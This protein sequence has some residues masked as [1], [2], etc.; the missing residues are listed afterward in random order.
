MAPAQQAWVSREFVNKNVPKPQTSFYDQLGKDSGV[1]YAGYMQVSFDFRSSLDIAGKTEK[2][3]ER[4]YGNKENAPYFGV[5]PAYQ[6]SN[7]DSDSVTGYLM[8]TLLIFA[9]GYLII[10]NIF[11]I[12]ISVNILLM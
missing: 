10:Y 6:T 4:L 1:K 2:L 5:N 12:N 3:A 11:R 7:A 8:F 9:A